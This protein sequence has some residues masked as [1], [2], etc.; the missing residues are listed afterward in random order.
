MITD[1][2]KLKHRTKAQSIFPRQTI[3]TPKY[4]SYKFLTKLIKA[5][6]NEKKLFCNEYD[7]IVAEIE[8]QNK[9]TKAE[10]AKAKQNN[11]NHNET[12]GN[13]HNSSSRSS[14][15]NNFSM[16]NNNSNVTQNMPSS[17]NGTGKRQL[18]PTVNKFGFLLRV[19]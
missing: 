5:P 19:K 9:E 12:G 18:L 7:Q 17:P 3:N 1:K 8:K 16:N 10:K 14:S 2:V 15:N 11:Q 4:I 13:N 6:K